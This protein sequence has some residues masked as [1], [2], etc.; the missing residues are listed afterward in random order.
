MFISDDKI[1]EVRAAS[2]I[3]DVVSDYVRLKKRGTNYFGLCPFHA[4]KT[5]SFS[6][7]PGIGIFKC[8]GCGVGGDVFQFMMRVENLSFPE[9]VR[10]LAEK[11]GIHLPVENVA[12]DFSNEI[13]SIYNALRFAARFFYS[14]LTQSEAGKPALEYL[15]NRGYSPKTITRF[16]LGY[17]PDSWDGLLKEAR[18][19]HI[20]PE[21]LEKAGLVVARKDGFYDRYRGRVIFPILSNVGKV[22]GFGGRLLSAKTDQPKYINSPETNVY[23]KSRVLYGLYQARQAIRAL[24]EALLVEGYTDV[25]TLHQA[26]V[27]NAVACSGTALTPEQIK[28]LS[29]YTGQITLLYDADSAGVNAAERG[30]DLVL[31]EGLSVYVVTLPAQEDPDSFVRRQGK[32]TFDA[33]L[34][35]NRLDFVAFKHRQGKRSGL[36]A[37]PEGEARIMYGI[38]AS[39]ARIK[40]PL[41]QETYL[42]RASDV[43]EVPD[44]RLYEA[45]DNHRRERRYK[46]RNRPIQHTTR[47]PRTNVD[48]H[49]TGAESDEDPVTTPS[50]EPLPQEKTLIRLMLEGGVPL[51][52]YILG[53]MGLDEFT[54]GAP[55][56]I[57]SHLITQYQENSVDTRPFVD[58]SFGEAVQRLTAEVMVDRYE[59]SENWEKKQNISVPRFNEIPFEAAASAMTL[60]KLIRVDEAIDI[61]LQKQYKVDYSSETFR[62]LQKESVA[63]LHLKQRIQ[64]REFLNR[65]KKT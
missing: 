62:S 28:A 31:E 58:G 60:L 18:D 61:N 2:D 16:G 5:A 35:Q 32:E 3:V 36:S 15:I 22:L 43:L 4:E 38:I 63:L 40:D 39:L 27:T 41:M 55:R 42:R 33:Y 23:N 17:A 64:R 54:E 45:L 13:E 7:N 57:V 51:I 49:D 56:D 37:T 52:E 65:N 11:A 6:V 44:I 24:E 47:Q 20:S 14:Q 30:I 29:R 50:V 34:K 46:N 12:S 8:F 26:G 53:N 10:T 21:T 19:K 48:Y 1:E 59:P 9:T 25:I